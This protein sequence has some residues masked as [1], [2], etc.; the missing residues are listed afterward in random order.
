VLRRYFAGYTVFGGFIVEVAGGS[1]TL[2]SSALGT[3]LRTQAALFEGLVTSMISEYR[4]ERRQRRP[5]SEHRQLEQVKKLLAGDPG[6]PGELGY[7]LDNWHVGAIARG[8]DVMPA[9]R[10]LAQASDRCLLLIRHDRETVWAWFGGR[11]RIEIAETARC[12]ASDWSGDALVALGEPARGIEG[13]RLTHQQAGAALRI[14]R[15]RSK[16]VVQYADVGLLA[17]IAQDHVLASSLRQLYLA[18]LSGGHDG[19]AALRETLRAYFIAGRNVSSA[20]SGLG[21]SRQTV[22]NRLRSIEEKL[23]RTLESCAPEV[24]IALRLEMS[25]PNP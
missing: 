6:D 5:R 11:R 1:T 12:L 8:G 14:S 2:R 16:G 21:V 10:G 4:R 23:G 20:A 24:E 9:L 17:A 15:H 25:L 22:R 13:W 19:G 18:P 7:E 3:I